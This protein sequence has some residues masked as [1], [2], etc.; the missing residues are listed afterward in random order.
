MFNTYNSLK[1]ML[2]EIPSLNPFVVWMGGVELD[3]IG[4]YWFTLGSMQIYMTNLLF[5]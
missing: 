2:G 3:P 4:K 1:H 5:I